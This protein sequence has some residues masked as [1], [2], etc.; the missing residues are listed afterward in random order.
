M[1]YLV[2]LFF[3]Y[4]DISLAYTLGIFIYSLTNSVLLNYMEIWLAVI[5]SIPIIVIGLFCRNN[6]LIIELGLNKLSK[7][8][9]KTSIK[10]GIF[11]V[12]CHVFIIFSLI[13]LP[14][15]LFLSIEKGTFN[16][17]VLSTLVIALLLTISLNIYRPRILGE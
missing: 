3:Y 6:K 7:V 8:I 14:F 13:F 1:N 5:F 16:S 4:S 10:N 17:G 15:S 2:R 9:G 11:L 12:I